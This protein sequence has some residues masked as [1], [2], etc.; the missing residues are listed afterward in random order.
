MSRIIE[1][2]EAHYDTVEVPLGKIYQ[3]HQAH[4]TLECD[5]GQILTFSGTSATVTCYGC[6]TDYGSLVHDIHYREEHLR[7][8]EVHPWYYDLQSQA[9]QHLQDETTYPED[10]PYRYNDVTEGLDDEE[11]W[12]GPGW[13]RRNSPLPTPARWWL[14][15][16]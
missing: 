15:L 14:L 11:R 13:V 5:C 3:W 9:D 8:E 16:T 10:S 6:G 4:V 7:D 1:R 12:K 2:I